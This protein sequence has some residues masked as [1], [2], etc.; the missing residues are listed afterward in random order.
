[1]ATVAFIC[2][3]RDYFV[4]LHQTLISRYFLIASKP[5]I[6]VRIGGFFIMRG[7]YVVTFEG[8]VIK[9]KTLNG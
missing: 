7:D 6:R 1:M 3:C 5:F 4:P 8:V 9:R 2:K